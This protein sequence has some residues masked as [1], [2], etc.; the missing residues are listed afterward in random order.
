MNGNK[1]GMAIIALALVVAL[2][3][4]LVGSVFIYF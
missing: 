3:V 2:V 1:K 4:S